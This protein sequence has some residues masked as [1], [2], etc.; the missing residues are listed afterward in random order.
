MDLYNANVSA[1]ASRHLRR[2]EIESYNQQLD[3]Q[4]RQKAKFLLDLQSDFD[5]EAIGRET[6]DT[7]TRGA[8]GLQLGGTLA[9]VSADIA[10]DELSLIGASRLPEADALR[11]A[12][13][14]LFGSAEKINSNYARWRGGI[15][16]NN[17][18]NSF[19]GATRGAGQSASEI[20]SAAQLEEATSIARVAEHD[21]LS[22]AAKS[23]NPA[24]KAGASSALKGGEKVSI[25]SG[26]KAGT[27]AGAKGLAKQ[28]SPLLNIGFAYQSASKLDEE[29]DASGQGF[30]DTIEEERGL[31]ATA[32]VSQIVSGVAEIG[33]IGVGA[34]IGLGLLSVAAAPVVGTLALI[35]AVAGATSAITGG[36]DAGLQI[37]KEQ[38]EADTEIDKKK[39]EEEAL[40]PDK[41]LRG[42]GS[43][44]I[45]E[46]TIAP[47]LR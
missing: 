38:A 4:Q 33:S 29:M 15:H 25:R 12:T 42:F 14:G 16:P 27:K 28:A 2:Q 18:P 40:I 6:R 22:L 17:V 36:I 19:G 34:A 9:T 41:P 7:T 37:D 35:G 20:R 26:L 45:V 13:K 24:L 39:A 23:A 31:E 47:K 44:N 46:G 3:A 30:I 5:V 10:A 43:S 32:D 1:R 21:G 11:G 8:K